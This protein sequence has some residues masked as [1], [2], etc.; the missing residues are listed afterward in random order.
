MM[1]IFRWP[2]RE[3]MYS[4]WWHFLEQVDFRR[5]IFTVVTNSGNKNLTPF[6]P[7]RLIQRHKLCFTVHDNICFCWEKRSCIHSVYI[8][9]NKNLTPFPPERRIKRHTLFL[10]CMIIYLFILLGKEEVYSE[11]LHLWEVKPPRKQDWASSPLL[12]T[13][14]DDM[15]L[16]LWEQKPHS[17]RRC[18]QSGYICGK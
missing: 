17:K 4:H 2:A 14:H 3:N 13:V 1:C 18:I 15:S 6:P 5:N 9:G 8:C 11:W 7:E 16:H 12:F 10:Q